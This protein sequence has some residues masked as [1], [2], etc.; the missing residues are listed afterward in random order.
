M[1]VKLGE[2]DSATDVFYLIDAIVMLLYLI[3]LDKNT[4]KDTF[5]KYKTNLIKK[6]LQWEEGHSWFKLE[7]DA[8]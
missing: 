5:S 2:H 3:L 8:F 1:E 4:V 7:T 6:L